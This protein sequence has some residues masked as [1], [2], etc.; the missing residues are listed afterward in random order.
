MRCL[1]ESRVGGGEEEEGEG[2]DLAVF[3]TFYIQPKFLDMTPRSI[4]PYIVTRMQETV[5]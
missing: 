3:W 4:L 1:S 5:K 2:E